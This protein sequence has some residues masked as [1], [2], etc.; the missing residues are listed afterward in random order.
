MH[1]G[2]WL[3]FRI[4]I[5]WSIYFIPFSWVNVMT[6]TI[7]LDR[8]AKINAIKFI[9]VHSWDF[10]LTTVHLSNSHAHSLSS[11]IFS[12]VIFSVNFSELLPLVSWTTIK[13][14]SQPHVVLFHS[15]TLMFNPNDKFLF[16]LSSNVRRCS[17]IIWL[18]YYAA[19]H[20]YSDSIYV[21]KSI[22]ILFVLP[23]FSILLCIAVDFVRIYRV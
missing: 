11:S 19:T 14:S 4:T 20:F 6:S 12:S 17:H 15:P 16:N 8:R 21:N 23:A 7:D 1:Y 22:F 10:Q 13:N 5:R 18:M 2:C 3:C 9:Y